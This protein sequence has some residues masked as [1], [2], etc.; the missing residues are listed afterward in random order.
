[1]R[2]ENNGKVEAEYRKNNGLESAITS[3]LAMANAKLTSE[4][5]KQMQS[6]NTSNSNNQN[7]EGSSGTGKTLNAE[8][9]K[10]I[11]TLGDNSGIRHVKGTEID[12]R[13]LFDNQVIKSTVKEVQSGVF[14]GQGTDGF[15]Y[16]FRAVSK[17]G[18]PTIDV[19]G[20][21]GLRKIKFLP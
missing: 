20:I 19:N 10:K 6:S 4:I 12:A 14:V 17:S 16:T 7:T 15:T 9:L 11:G 8:E 2:V 5:N 13:N 21:S 1:M 3:A 18:P